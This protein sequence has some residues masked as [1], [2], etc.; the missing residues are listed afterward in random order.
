MEHDLVDIRQY[1]SIQ[2]NNRS[3]VNHQ[4]QFLQIRHTANVWKQFLSNQNKSAIL[5][6][7]ALSQGDH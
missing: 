6:Y 7:K 1:N 2:Y 5:C 4:N 3:S